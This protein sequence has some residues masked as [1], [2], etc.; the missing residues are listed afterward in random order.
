MH[1]ASLS[2][3]AMTS[4]V[5]LWAF[6]NL[7]ELGDW[8]RLERGDFAGTPPTEDDFHVSSQQ[9]RVRRG[10]LESRRYAGSRDIC[11]LVGER[12]GDLG[13][14]EEGEE[15][16]GEE[17]KEEEEEDGSSSQAEVFEELLGGVFWFW[18]GDLLWGKYEWWR[19]RKQP[20]AKRGTGL[21]LESERE[22]EEVE[23]W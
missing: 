12:R 14:S 1:S 6:P 9:R 7:E 22:G 4:R 21:G 8:L 19:M 23:G 18:E 16:A 17:E 11:F 15:V 13:L 3:D 20:S 5:P 10:S 2:A